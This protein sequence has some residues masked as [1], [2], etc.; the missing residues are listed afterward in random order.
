MIK[1]L[2]IKQMFDMMHKEDFDNPSP[3]LINLTLDFLKREDFQG[4]EQWEDQRIKPKILNPNCKVA[5][6]FK[7]ITKDF[8]PPF[9]VKT[10]K[11]VERLF[12]EVKKMKK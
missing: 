4:G 5:K 2:A 7:K 3:A 1:N 8:Q 10:F 12:K 11:A 9:K 6:D